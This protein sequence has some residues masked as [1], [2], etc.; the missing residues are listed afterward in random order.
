MIELEEART[1]LLQSAPVLEAVA[2]PLDEAPGCVLAETVCADR[3][4]PPYDRAAMDGY[5]VRAADLNPGGDGSTGS[6]RCVGEIRPGEAWGDVL[7]PGTCVAI[8]TGAAV[9][10]GADAVVEVEATETGDW[11]EGMVVFRRGAKPGDNV[12][13]RGEDAEE[14]R[15]LA[16]PGTPLAPHLC[17]LLALCGHTQVHVYRQPGVAMLSTGS[18]IVAAEATPSPFQIRDANRTMIAALLKRYGFGSA[19]DLGITPDDRNELR[20]ALEAGLRHDVLLISGGVSR[21]TTDLVPDVLEELGVSCLFSGVAMKPGKPLWAGVA[22]EG[23]VVVALPGNPLAVLVHVSEMAVPLLRRMSGHPQPVLPLLPVTL[24]EDIKVKGDRLTLHPVFVE[25]ST[26]C[27]FL[28]RPVAS[29]GSA[30]LVG[31]AGANGFV[32]LPPGRGTWERGARAE[33]RVW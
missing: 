22:P 30:D 16:T 12:S 3:P 1:I 4:I 23:C 33:A 9:P 18:E 28:A 21:G 20:A 14:G 11:G 17:G 25:G 24:A 29:H 31:M 26:N 32:F 27:G 7:Q 13:P 2:L 15:I 19:T 10:A 6:L 8:M 5:A